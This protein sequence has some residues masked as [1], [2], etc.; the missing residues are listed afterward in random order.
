M[1][2][3]RIHATAVAHCYLITPFTV[4]NTEQTVSGGHSVLPVSPGHARHLPPYPPSY[5]GRR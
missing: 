4:P 3:Y 5:R 1:Q 2:G